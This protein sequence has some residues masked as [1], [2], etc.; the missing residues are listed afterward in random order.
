ML[1]RSLRIKT[2]NSAPVYLN[3]PGYRDH[4]K[5]SKRRNWIAPP[6]ELSIEPVLQARKEKAWE[7]LYDM[8]TIDDGM[9]AHVL[10]LGA[11][12]VANGPDPKAA[13]GYYIFVANGTM[14]KEGLAGGEELPKW[15]MTVVE[16]TDDE[17]EIRAGPKGLEAIVMEFPKEE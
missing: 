12:M 6:V 4:L 8:S 15:S 11:N 14:M 13:G 16:T 3:K 2:G 1:F 7:P 5:P 10:R 9:A 17:F